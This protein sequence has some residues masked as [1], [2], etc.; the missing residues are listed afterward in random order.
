MNR[1]AQYT[2]TGIKLMHH[3]NLLKALK[4]GY[5]FPVSL[6]VAPT[7]I[8]N[9]NCIFCSNVNRNKNEN[10]SKESIF[11]LLT[12]LKMRGLKTVEWTGGGDPTLYKHINEVMSFAASLTLKQGFITNGIE[13]ADKIAPENIY[14]LKWLRISLNSLDYGKDIKVP[15]YFHGVLGF[16]YVMNKKT[17]QETINSI[18]DHVKRYNPIYVRIVPDCQATDEEQVK[19]NEKFSN[20]VSKWPPPFFFQKKEFARPERCWWGYVKPFVLHDGFVYYCSSVVLNDSADKQFHW[21]YRWC[22]IDMLPKKYDFPIIPFGT[23]S[24]NHCVFKGQNNLVDSILNPTTMSDF[25]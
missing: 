12:Q 16:S 22:S 1:E 15:S 8:C 4:G 5:A 14:Y 23:E 19:N 10:L 17:T 20:M 13:F 11:V 25:V 7:S 24:C 21:K 18:F 6:Q 3:P 2:S 9:L